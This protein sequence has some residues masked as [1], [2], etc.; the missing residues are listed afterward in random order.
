MAARAMTCKELVELITDY[1]EDA[2]PPAERA[3]FEAHLGRCDGCT[4]YLDQM[5]RTIALSGRLTEESIAPGA[6]EELLDVFQDWKK[7]QQS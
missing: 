3:R 1:L 5:R 7:G 4:N 6:Q 2:L